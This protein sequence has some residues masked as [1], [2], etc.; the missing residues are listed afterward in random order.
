M[1]EEVEG[2]H[3]HTGARVRADL[4]CQASTALQ[5]RGF[6]AGWFV[7]ETKFMAFGR[8]PA[9]RVDETLAQ[10]TSY[11]ESEFGVDGK[12]VRPLFATV[13]INPQPP[14]PAASRPGW[15][16][17]AAQQQRWEHGL[18]LVARM[19]TGHFDFY[20]DRRWT[21]KFGQ[22][23]FFDSTTGPGEAMREGPHGML[24]QVGSRLVPWKVGV[25]KA[26]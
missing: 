4:M 8:D 22:K 25:L 17:F 14:A 26:R 19:G 23:L 7:A 24:R 5:S 13:V 16:A 12:W 10:A 15:A 18:D 6:P 2:R 1:R 11:G 21:L 9:V 20:S 3:L